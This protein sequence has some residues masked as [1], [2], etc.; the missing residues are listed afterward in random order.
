MTHLGHDCF[1]I[2]WLFYEWIII[3]DRKEQT[4]LLVQCPYFTRNS[5]WTSM[6]SRFI[7]CIESATYVRERGW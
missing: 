6:N 5:H 1:S 2:S 4:C 7:Y 3:V